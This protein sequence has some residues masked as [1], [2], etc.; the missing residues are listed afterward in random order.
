MKPTNLLF[1][2]TDQYSRQMTGAYGHPQLQT[3]HL[4]RLAERGTRFSHA[5]TP[6]PICVP[7][8]AA[9]ATGRHVH[10]LRLWDNAFPYAGQVP[11]WGHQLKANGFHTDAIG[12]L[13]YRRQGDDNGFVEEI[14]V[15]Y[16]VDG[17]GD[18]LGAIREDPPL[19]NTRPDVDS[20]RVGDSSYLQYDRRLT[21]RACGWL[22]QHQH[23]SSPW[24]LFLSY[25]CPHP[26]YVAP[27]GLYA[28]YPPENIPMPLQW[29]QRDWPDHPA[30][31]YLRRFFNFEAPF[32][33]ASIRHMNAA[34]YAVCTFVDTQV[35]RVL[36]TL[37]SLRLAETTRIIFT[38]DHGEHAGA[39]GLFGK[40]TMYEE[41]AG[42]PLIVAGPDLPQGSIV[43]T[44]VS[45]VDCC[46]S[47][48]EAVGCPLPEADLPG[49]SLWTLAAS[50]DQPRTVLSEYH[51]LG[52]QNAFY[53]L[54]D[55]RY[56][57]VYYV[58]DRPQLFDLETDPDELNDLSGSA[59][60]ADVCADFEK[61]LRAILDP[62]AVDA[63][64]KA[65]QAALIEANG[66]RD[67]VIARGWFQN[68]PAPGEKA[69]FQ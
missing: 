57:Y 25:V 7:A 40:F 20:A 35:G 61:R 23:D 11:G 43:N 27:E 28:L 30:M 9:L 65:D 56:K 48:L 49:A 5:Y 50:G 29:Q 15:M 17:L 18:I 68:S 55:L 21:E 36:E 32:D 46:P 37:D 26:P 51:A 14:D 12:K 33:E 38:S 6:C 66:G 39:R 4:D 31:R 10:Q 1:I 13:H 8:R 62:E 34:Y 44:P 45:L 69:S 2:L 24:V 22:A 58:G 47:I 3:P 53:M 42:I 52:S 41:S 64:A 54:R 19:R 16:V 59:E 60:H 67:A 63:L